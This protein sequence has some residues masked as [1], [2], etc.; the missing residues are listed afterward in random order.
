MKV[1]HHGDRWQRIARAALDRGAAFEQ[2]EG[3]PR[4]MLVWNAYGRCQSPVYREVSTTIATKLRTGQTRS[5]YD[6]G[7]E[8]T[9]GSTIEL[10]VRCRKCPPCLKAR[11]AMWRSRS[12]TELALAG[13]TWFGTLTLSPAEHFKVTSNARLRLARQGFDFDRLSEEEQFAERHK[14]ISPEITRFLKRVRKEANV[15]LRFILVAEAHKSGMPHY[16]LLIHEPVGMPVRHRVLKEQWRLG[17]SNFKLVEAGKVAARYVCKY[18]AKSS[19]ARVRAS[20]G[21][22]Q[23]QSTP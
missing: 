12:E 11:A 10:Y 20:V 17:F 19:I 14:S 2:R 9:H 3:V 8:R 4:S 7:T 18:L 15:P 22:G 13:R 6:H 5:R 23:R 16:H 1:L 21:Y